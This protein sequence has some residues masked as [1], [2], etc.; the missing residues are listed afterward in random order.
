MSISTH[1]IQWKMGVIGDEKG[2]MV[3]IW[4]YGK[5]KKKG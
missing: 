4:P 3:E 2:E 1:K 5:G